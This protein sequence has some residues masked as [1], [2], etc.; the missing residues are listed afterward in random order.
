MAD[1]ILVQNVDTCFLAVN[2]Y[3]YHCKPLHMAAL[4]QEAPS[5]EALLKHLL[6]FTN[7]SKG[8]CFA[9]L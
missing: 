7:P 2:N 6:L 1:L 4:P 9:V 3:A 5:R 8:V